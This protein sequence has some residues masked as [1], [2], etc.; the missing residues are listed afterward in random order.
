[1]HDSLL[2]DVEGK[3]KTE[4]VLRTIIFG[5]VGGKIKSDLGEPDALFGIWRIKWNMLDG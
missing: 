4:L 5:E 3:N 1:M 2:D